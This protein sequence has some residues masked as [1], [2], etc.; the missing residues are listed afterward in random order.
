M[1]T[2]ILNNIINHLIIFEIAG[3]LFLNTAQAQFV[4]VSEGKSPSKNLKMKQS[5]VPSFE[6]AKNKAIPR[7]DIGEE[8]LLKSEN[9]V[10]V[11][12]DKPK[13]LVA[14]RKNPILK[15]IE[16]DKKSV[17]I[18][19]VKSAK[20][21]TTEKA[22]KSV[23]NINPLSEVYQP[24]I[25]DPNI[26]VK[27]ITLFTDQEFKILE[28]QIYFDFIKNFEMS[29]TE[30]AELLNDKEY[31][32]QAA[33][34]YGKAARELKLFSEFKKYELLVATKAQ[35]K[36]LKNLAIKELV[37]N[38][39]DL[40]IND[41]E[42]IDAIIQKEDFDLMGFDSYNFYRAKFYL[43]KAQ[44]SLVEESL[45][46]ISEKSEFFPESKFISALSFYR[47]GKIDFAIDVLSELLASQSKIESIKTLANLTLARIYFQK[48]D[49]IKS[50]EYYIK[51]NKEHPLWLAAMVELA[52]AQ[53]LTADYEGA[54]G[55]MFSLH[56]DFF[57]NAY[58]PESYVVRT[59][60]YLNLCQ[61]GDGIQVLNSLG[62]K[63][64]PYYGRIEKYI[65]SKKGAGEYYQT[66]KT[67]LKN[68]ELKE[69][70]GIPRSLIV[71]LARHPSYLG[72]QKQLNR[73]EDEISQFNQ[74]TIK[75]IQREKDLIQKQVSLNKELGEI[76]LAI[77]DPKKNA[78]LLKIEEQL[79]LKKLQSFKY[80]QQNIKNSRDVVKSMRD[81]AFKRIDS[82]KNRYRENAGKAIKS[83]LSVIKNDLK[84]LLDQNEL[85]QYEIYSGAGEHIR[86]QTVSQDVKADD[87]KNKEKILA[88]LAKDK[89][90]KVKWNFKGEIWE[91]EI[92]HFRSSL[93]NVCPKDE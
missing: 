6:F 8:A 62:K 72:I 63:Y 81:F 39:T 9:P 78:E 13:D 12:K 92:G 49:Y 26:K 48:S 85:L 33:Y 25:L 45:A 52:W 23:P 82:E 47:Q 31:G 27:D 89:D 34:H 18:G 67:W 24:Q 1:K 21:I 14:V 38:I 86:Y 60:S 32:F 66:V 40:E 30:F 51:V 90:Q 17:K 37:A 2:R 83:R 42:E 15:S 58:N 4:K 29:L 70:D 59:I 79:I 88:Q 7:I 91:D 68:T 53:I 87:E 80:Q 36:E 55:N 41:V 19:E 35:S 3:I 20:I 64:A 93:K 76:K 44:L 69:V 46:L 11:I 75:L 5:K 74:V 28:G 50:K 56:T 77:L 73:L 16:L 65:D 71:E 54:A 22:L 57:K 84:D 61:F 43:E 10:L